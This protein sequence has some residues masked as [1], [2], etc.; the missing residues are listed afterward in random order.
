M[1]S[2]AESLQ[3]LGAVTPS[4]LR[5]R[6]ALGT[7]LLSNLW[8][9]PLPPNIEACRAAGFGAVVFCAVELQPP[10]HLLGS[11]VES[12]LCPLNDDPSVRLTQQQFSQAAMAGRRVAELVRSGTAV[13]VTCAQGRNRS[14]LVSALALHLLNG[15][16]GTDAIRYVRQRRQHALTNQD[17]CQQIIAR[18]G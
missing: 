9:G 3:L 10:S 4:E 12:I 13:L 6:P 17:F 7:R 18:I 16:R 8:I 5:L 14:G 15:W 2:N 11:G 1:S